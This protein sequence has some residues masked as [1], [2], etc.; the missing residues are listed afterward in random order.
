MEPSYFVDNGF[1]GY[2][3]WY[4]LDERAMGLVIT[5][6]IFWVYNGMMLLGVI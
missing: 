5:G 2:T 1:D 4:T 6:E 3:H